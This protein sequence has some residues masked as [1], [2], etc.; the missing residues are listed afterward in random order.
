MQSLSA[1]ASDLFEVIHCKIQSALPQPGQQLMRHDVQTDSLYDIPVSDLAA[2]LSEALQQHA[3]LQFSY[4]FY[5]LQTMDHSKELKIS[6]AQEVK[7]ILADYLRKV[8]EPRLIRKAEEILAYMCRAHRIFATEFVEL[9]LW[10][11]PITEF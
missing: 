3:D 2:N 6:E 1:T 7:K 10:H 9:Y 11:F 5:F 4:L 8:S